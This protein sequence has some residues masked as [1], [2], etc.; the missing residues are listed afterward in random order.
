M[1]RINDPDSY[2]TKETLNGSDRLIGSDSENQDRTMNFNVDSI[3]NFVANNTQSGNANL[4]YRFVATNNEDNL[5]DGEFTIISGELIFRNVDANGQNNSTLFS[6]LN[7]NASNLIFSFNNGDLNYSYY[8]VEDLSAAPDT[9]LFFFGLTNFGSLA[10]GNLTNGVQYFFNYHVAPAAGS[11]VTN[12]SYNATSRQVIS[13]TGTDATLPF[14][15]DTAAGLIERNERR[16]FT[17]TLIDLGGTA[18]YTLVDGGSVYQRIGNMV[19]FTAILNSINT[20]GSPTGLL[21]I[22]GLPYQ[23]TS[24]VQHSFS[25]SRFV[26]GNVPFY[27]IY[28]SSVTV[29]QALNIEFFIQNSLSNELTNTTGLSNVTITNG[30]I[31]VSGFYPINV[32]SSDF[33]Q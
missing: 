1:P 4:P 21:R 31:A 30:S 18:T 3:A 20:S 12:L 7:S 27:S 17:P 32:G 13:N 5:A 9:N 15:T 16:N 2:P 19:Y 25:I 26:G 22:G 11:S 14:A 29:S 10:L 6:N 28:P 8:T 23:I 33:V 24:N